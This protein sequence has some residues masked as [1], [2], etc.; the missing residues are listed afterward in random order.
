MHQFDKKRK[1]P[2]LSGNSTIIITRLLSLIYSHIQIPRI[3]IKK[4]KFQRKYYTIEA[5]NHKKKK[6]KQQLLS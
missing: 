1:R 4:K 5:T 6:K 3:Q 2:K